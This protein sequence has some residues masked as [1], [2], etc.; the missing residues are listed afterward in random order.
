M[1]YPKNLSCLEDTIGY[2]FKNRRLCMVALTHSS[3]SNEMKTKDPSIVCNERMEFL[4]DSVLS[5]ITS[6][7]IFEKYT[8]LPEGE[9]TKIRASSVCENALFEYSKKISLGDYIYLGHG[10]EM[11]GSRGHK[12]ILADAF[13]ALLA[14][15]YLDS[16]MENAKKFLLPFISEH[17]NAL[18]KAGRAEDFKSLL[19]QFI[20]KSPGDVLEYI[21]TGEEGPAHNKKFYFEV[22][23]NNTVI[24]KGEGKTKREAEQLSAREALILFGELSENT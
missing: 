18:I 7:Y 9:L 1:S 22:R 3:Y 13:E 10:E 23:L 21:Q 16:G 5:I 12:A 19:Q 17:I 14:S 15:I 8:D 2:T 4:G 11:S 24:G 20:Q 6:E